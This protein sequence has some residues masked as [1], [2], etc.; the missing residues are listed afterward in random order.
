MLWNAKDNTK[1]MKFELL[2]EDKVI[3]LER[4]RDDRQGKESERG[5]WNWIESLEVIAS[6][7]HVLQFFFSHFCDDDAQ[8]LHMSKVEGHRKKVKAFKESGRFYIFLSFSLLFSC[9]S[10]L[11]VWLS[12]SDVC[13]SFI[14]RVWGRRSSKKSGEGFFFLKWGN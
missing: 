8:I 12:F 4:F 13:V 11:S 7:L 2:T 1:I 14:H 9:T 10:E 3:K 5:H 6:C